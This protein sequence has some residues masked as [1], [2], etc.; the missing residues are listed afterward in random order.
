MK[1]KP[2]I[3]LT[4]MTTPVWSDTMPDT[5]YCA[6]HVTCF[7]MDSKNCAYET[8]STKAISSQPYFHVPNTGQP[9]S[10]KDYQFQHA[11]FKSSTNVWCL[12][13]NPYDYAPTKINLVPV[14][15][16]VYSPAKGSAWAG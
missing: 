11:E 13:Y 16:H 8:T 3:L 9:V 1:L 10:I 2:W 14:S 15:G 6:E 5:L 4:L 12:Y 7:S